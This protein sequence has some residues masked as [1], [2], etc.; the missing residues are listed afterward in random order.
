MR[1]AINGFGRIGRTFYRAVVA[2]GPTTGIDVVAVNDVVPIDQLAYLL[3]FDSVAGRLGAPVEVGEG[4]LRVGGDEL[5][6]LSA[7]A[8]SDAP[9]RDLGVDV[10]VESSRLFAAADKARGHLDA[11]A[12]TVVVTAPSDGADATFVFG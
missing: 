6:V 4:V 3:E 2:R 8:P 11:G 7:R 5:R 9:W 1:I 12:R 10:V